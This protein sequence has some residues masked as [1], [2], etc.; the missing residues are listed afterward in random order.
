MKQSRNNRQAGKSQPA[1]SVPTPPAKGKQQGRQAKPTQ[2]S[3]AN[4]PAKANQVAKANALSK[5]TVASPLVLV[6][7]SS[8]LCLLAALF[9]YWLLVEKNGFYLYAVQEQNLWISDPSFLRDKLMFVGGLSQWVGC[10]LTQFF[11]YPWLGTLILIILWAILFIV[12]RFAFRLRGYRQLFMLLPLFALLLSEV[13]LGYWLYYAKSPGYWFVPTLCT[14]VLYFAFWLIRSLKGW[15]QTGVLVVLTAVLYPCIGCW[16]LALPLFTA[17]DALC[18]KAERKWMTLAISAALILLVPLIYYQFYGRLRLGGAWTVNLPIFET[19]SAHNYWMSLPFILCLL[20]PLLCLLLPL[21]KRLRMHY[22]LKPVASVVWVA[23]LA[24][25]TWH[26]SYRNFNYEEEMRM[27]R[28]IRENRHIDVFA[29]LS[30]VTGPMTRQMVLAKNIALMH[31]NEGDYKIGEKMFAYDNSG[32]PPY[33]RDSL[34]VHLAQTC[35]MEVYYQ[36]GKAN[37]ACRWAIE[38]GVE[39]GFNVEQLKTLVRTSMMNGEYRAARKYI[40][41]LLNTTFQKEWAGEWLD[42]LNDKQK[43]YRSKDYRLIN[44]LRVYENTIDGDEGLIEMYI[45]N[46][47]SHMQKRDPKFQEQTLVYALVQKDIQLFWQR[48]FQ[49]AL[50]HEKEL[51]PIHYQ[52]AAFLYGHLE[53]DVD[54]SGMPFNQERIVQ[55]YVNFQNATNNLL[56]MG[57]T[58]EQVGQAI[59]NEYG[60]TFWWFYY[61]CRNVHS[62]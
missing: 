6:L 39:Y 49:Y 8:I 10:Y 16:A 46:Y 27:F 42:M 29:E 50:L 19:E 4:Q 44:P 20:C 52:E 51:M 18:Q 37:F 41:I 30:K 24:L 12:S 32:E 11:F 36:Y 21:L 34:R 31:V 54:I 9:A 45:I 2:I 7:S 14:L 40:D 56:R 47:F 26:F 17:I 23:L 43:Y 60:D 25:C 53:H 1:A 55:R 62:Y 61:F 59:K 48:F 38:N 33:T 13:D 58:P 22:V 35:G 28:A 5:P 3:K 15:W 57:M